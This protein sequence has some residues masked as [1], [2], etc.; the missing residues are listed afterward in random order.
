MNPCSLGGLHLARRKRFRA[1]P[2]PAPNLGSAR[3]ALESW[4]C[5]KR[6]A[7]YRDVLVTETAPRGLNDPQPLY[8]GGFSM[9]RLGTTTPATFLFLRASHETGF[10]AGFIAG[11]ELRPT[12]VKYF[13]PS[14][15]GTNAS[16]AGRRSPPRATLPIETKPL[17]PPSNQLNGRDIGQRVGAKGSISDFRR[18]VSQIQGFEVSGPPA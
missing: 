4:R 9:P 16:L 2:P 3:G 11:R 10:R 14:L 6:S 17:S 7:K 15:L 13:W 5:E 18:Q 8:G 1:V 12:S